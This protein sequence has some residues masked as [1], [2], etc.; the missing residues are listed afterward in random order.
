MAIEP[1]LSRKAGRLELK[2]TST[3]S[4]PLHMS[5]MSSSLLSTLRERC[6]H[7]LDDLVCWGLTSLSE[8]HFSASRAAWNLLD[9]VPC[10]NSVGIF[11]KKNKG[12]RK[13]S[14]YPNCYPASPGDICQS[15]R[16]AVRATI[17]SG[18]DASRKYKI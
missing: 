11:S 4:V 2:L 5:P 9:A 3:W 7:F 13:K 18:A 1:M 15:L 16:S 6:M 14:L 8:L 17:G 10:L 12:H